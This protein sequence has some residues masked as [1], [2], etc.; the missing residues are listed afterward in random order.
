MGNQTAGTQL[1]EKK[2]AGVSSQWEG[3]CNVSLLGL[4][5]NGESGGV[6]A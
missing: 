6:E 1:G 3:R 5:E 2:M 4:C